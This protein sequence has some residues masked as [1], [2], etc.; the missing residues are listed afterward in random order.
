MLVLSN[1]D[2]GKSCVFIMINASWFGYAVHRE[3][4]FAKVLYKSCSIAKL[5]QSS[6]G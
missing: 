3:L 1:V 6:A 4:F 2:I 5:S